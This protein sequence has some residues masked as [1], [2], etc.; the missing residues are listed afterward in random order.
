[1]IAGTIECNRHY[2]RLAAERHGEGIGTFIRAFDRRSEP[3]DPWV[4]RATWEAL[5]PYTRFRGGQL[6]LRAT[7]RLSED[8]LIDQD[9]IDFDIIKEVAE[10]SGHSLKQLEANPYYGRIQTVGDFVQFITFQPRINEGEQR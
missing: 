7:D 2:R 3:F 4:L 9:D 5:V 6:P 8:L 10:R 1:M